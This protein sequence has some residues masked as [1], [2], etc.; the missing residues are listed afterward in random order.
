IKDG[1]FQGDE[2]DRGLEVIVAEINRLKKIIN[3]MILL[4]KLDSNEVAYH[5]ENI[6]VSE[7]VQLTIDRVLPM[8]ADKQ[9]TI[10]HRI[11]IDG[12]IH[13]D[14][15]KILQALLNIVTNG[16]RHAKSQVYIEVTQEN[17]R[18]CISVD[19][20]GE[21]VDEELMPQLFERFIKGKDGETGLGLAISRAIVERSQ[22]IIRVEDS[23]AGG[24]R[25]I[26]IL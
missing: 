17:D 7:L 16:I 8:A 6:Y 14:Q 10:N 13:V 25:F 21:G 11:V 24:A 22:G 19:D 23:P 15:G 9:I 3:E 4:A 12:I 1:V 18:F 5:E 2:A 20:D 26:I